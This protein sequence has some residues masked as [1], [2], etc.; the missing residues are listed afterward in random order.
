VR[1]NMDW[2]D[3]DAWY[4]GLSVAVSFGRQTAV[5]TAARPA[6]DLERNDPAVG[7]DDACVAVNDGSGAR[8]HA[9]DLAA[10]SPGRLRDEAG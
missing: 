9:C 3:R 6:A 4:G 10:R 5:R 7:P 2:Y 1:G 8:D